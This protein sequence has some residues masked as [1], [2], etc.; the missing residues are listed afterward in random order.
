MPAL[1]RTRVASASSSSITRF[2]ALTVMRCVIWIRSS[3]S[4]STISA[5]R[6]AQ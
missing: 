2:S 5:S 6:G 1:P 4:P 3:I